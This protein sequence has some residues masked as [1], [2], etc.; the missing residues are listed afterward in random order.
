[1][2]V[3][4]NCGRRNTPGDPCPFCGEGFYEIVVNETIFT[5]VSDGSEGSLNNARA[6]LCAEHFDGPIQPD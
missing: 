3:D 6:M 5:V 1:M 4:C 2:W